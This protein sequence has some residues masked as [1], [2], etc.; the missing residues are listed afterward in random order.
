MAK[1]YELDMTQ[2]SLLKKMILYSIPLMFTSLLQSLYNA[3]DIVVLGRFAGSGALASVGATSSI[4]NLMLN[5]F[6]A[7]SIGTGVVIAKSYGAKDF[8]KT[9]R[10]L[11]TSVFIALIFGTI[12]MLIGLI[13]AKP[14]L[15]LMQTPKEIIDGSVL[16]M[17]IFFMGAPA[18]LVYNFGAMAIRSMGD[19]K[20][21]LI[22]L[23][24]SGIANVVLNLVFV[25]V[26][27]MSVAGVALATTISQYISAILILSSLIK[28]KGYSH[29]D[30][31]KLRI[32]KKEIL[33]IIKI[34]IPAGIQGMVFSFSNVLI[35]STVNS[36]GPAYVA[37]SSAASNI[38]NLVYVVVNSGYHASVTM[39]GQNYGAKKM[40]RVNKSIGVCLSFVLVVG[41]IT[42]GL[43][44]IFA[45][46][47]LGIYTTDIDVIQKGAERLTLLSLFYIIC[48]MM[49]TLVGGTRG[50]GNS[51]IPMVVAILGVC[52]VRIVWLYTVF[53]MLPT[54]TMLFISY[55]VSWTATGLI[56][57]LCFLMYKNKV[58]KRMCEQEAGK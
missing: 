36:F 9:Q 54:F 42:G 6:I 52:G 43:V 25:I 51:F 44:M 8:L 23:T 30:I 34:G 55:P 21:P 38:E 53:K 37:G 49:D 2:G 4:I 48:G 27:K 18:S 56:Q 24:I 40:D 3:A 57:L 7:I 46:D 10:A 22:F 26:L 11:H 45:K 5:L 1:N 14:A 47:L 32:H 39:V 35:Q 33:E 58:K 28:S 15:L 13:F 29:L 20:R 50:L 31:K 19:T 17:R 12:A 41:L 16:Y